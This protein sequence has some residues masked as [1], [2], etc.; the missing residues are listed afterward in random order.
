MKTYIMSIPRAAKRRE[1]TRPE[2]LKQ[3]F[4]EDKLLYWSNEEEDLLNYEKVSDLM[5]KASEEF[6]HFQR[7]IDINHIHKNIRKISNPSIIAHTWSIFRIWRHG[8]ENNAFPFIFFHDDFYPTQPYANYVR[9]VEIAEVHSDGKWRYIALNGQDDKFNNP[10]FFGIHPNEH[11]YRER[12]YVGEEKT[13]CQELP[14]GIADT[15]AIV[16]E[17]GVDWLTEIYEKWNHL[18]T[19][20]HVNKTAEHTYSLCS[21]GAACIQGENYPSMMHIKVKGTSKPKHSEKMDIE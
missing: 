7:W 19:I 1:R 16:S 2:F 10:H 5:K 17:A 6:P 8:K 12:K 11:A 9:A 15:A 4:P 21:Q 20:L 18:E 13:L 3:G 14:D